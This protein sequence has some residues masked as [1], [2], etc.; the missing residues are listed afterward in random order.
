[1]ASRSRTNGSSAEP[2]RASRSDPTS[3]DHKLLGG[4]HLRIVRGQKQ[5][6]GGDVVR[7]EFVGQ[8]LLALELDLASLVSKLLANPHFKAEI[9]NQVRKELLKN[10]RYYGNIFGTYAQKTH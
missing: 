2:S 8:A 9:V 4:A 5:H 1:M 10:A 7:H 6:H 3:V